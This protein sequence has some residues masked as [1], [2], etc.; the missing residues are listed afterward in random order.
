MFYLSSLFFFFI[1]LSLCV[2]SGLVFSNPRSPWFSH[3][4]ANA[5]KL[6]LPHRPAAERHTLPVATLINNLPARRL[7]D[8]LPRCSFGSTEATT[9][10]YSRGGDVYSPVLLNA[11]V[12]FRQQA[13]SL[14]C[15]YGLD[16]RNV[17]YSCWWL[18]ATAF[19]DASRFHLS[20][21]SGGPVMVRTEGDAVKTNR[22]WLQ[23][24]KTTKNHSHSRRRAVLRTPARAENFH[25][26]CEFPGRCWQGGSI[27]RP[28]TAGE[29]Y[30]RRNS[31]HYSLR[32]VAGDVDNPSLRKVPEKALLLQTEQTPGNSPTC[33]VLFSLPVSP[34]KPTGAPAPSP[35][36]LDAE[37]FKEKWAFEESWQITLN[38][39]GTCYE[40]QYLSH[41][42][43]KSSPTDFKCQ[44]AA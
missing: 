2:P 27:A 39:N 16:C 19:E 38:Y 35:L 14:R 25:R 33:W 22:N 29:T 44:R 42:F 8:P 3:S 24:I 6:Q 17:H 23:D 32:A 13:R 37:G 41:C 20:G 36:F 5:P 12:S 28:M 9:D 31:S 21:N 18:T 40:N 34:K 26:A 30:Y 1:R 4:P 10:I 7:P 11:A 43:Q 15:V